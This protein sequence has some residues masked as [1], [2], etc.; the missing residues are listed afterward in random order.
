MIEKLKELFPKTFDAVKPLKIGIYE[1]LVEQTDFETKDIK[2]FLRSYC[3]SK[4]YIE[5]FKSKF[6]YD[7]DGKEIARDE[8]D[9]QLAAYRMRQARKSSTAKSLLIEKETLKKMNQYMHSKYEFLAKLLPLH[10][11]VVDDLVEAEKAK[12]G[13][14]KELVQ[15]YLNIHQTSKLYLAKFIKSKSMYDFRGKGYDI[16]DAVRERKKKLFTKKFG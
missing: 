12:K 7:L 6:R 15:K 14:D 4:I 5:S 13:Y 8:K 11:S 3:K 2:N 16:D 1:D 9:I 10:M